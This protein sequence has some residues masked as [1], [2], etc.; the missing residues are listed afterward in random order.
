MFHH[1]RFAPFGLFG[2]V[3]GFAV[4]GVTAQTGLSDVESEPGSLA[5]KTAA[6][7]FEIA[8]PTIGAEINEV[9]AGCHG[10]DGEGGKD[11]EYPRLAGLPARFI[12]AQLLFFRDRSRTN[13]AMVEYIDERQMPDEDIAHISVYLA[14]I[15]LPSR[16]PP[17]DPGGSGI[18]AYQR[19]LDAERVVQIPHAP[20]DA[21]RGATLYRRECA[22][23][24]GRDGG[25]NH[26]EG[27]PMLAG[28][29][30]AY[31][32]RQIPKYLDKR[33]IHDPSAPDDALLTEFSD[34]EIGDIF[35][36]LSRLD[37]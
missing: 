37:D 12:A 25:G 11:G 3:I 26:D 36:Y 23:C 6:I 33:R 10:T 14:E 16:L 19:L 30:T 31:L 9:C 4:T 20:G 32:W 8:D 28:Q 7:P 24:H 29:Y 18:N 5:A 2:A 27:V 21:E 17:V 22:S 13:M 1:S 35:A 15:E 34:A